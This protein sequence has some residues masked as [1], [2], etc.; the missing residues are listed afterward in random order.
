MRNNNSPSRY[1][2]STPHKRNSCLIG[3]SFA[4]GPV[5]VVCA[6]RMPKFAHI[7]RPIGECFEGEAV[8]PTADGDRTPA[9]TQMH[10]V[11]RQALYRRYRTTFAKASL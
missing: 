10:E 2:E 3:K 9:K 6:G 8:S 4:L 7:I 11:L 1:R 5:C